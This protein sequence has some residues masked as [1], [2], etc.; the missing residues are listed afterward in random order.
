MLGRK[1]AVK[2]RDGMPRARKIVFLSSLVQ[3][4]EE[5]ND[6]EKF[7][8]TITTDRPP[9][10]FRL[11]AEMDLIYGRARVWKLAQFMNF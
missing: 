3:Q 9:Q 7:T 6:K 2:L 1:L 4:N 11:R 8:E 10:S 5:H